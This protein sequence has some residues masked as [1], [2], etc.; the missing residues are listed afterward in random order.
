[1]RSW[2]KGAEDEEITLF[3]SESR[4]NW[5]YLAL[6]DAE[7]DMEVESSPRHLYVWTVVSGFQLTPLMGFLK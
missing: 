2:K 7:G 4:Q 1:M 3:C 5:G 6:V